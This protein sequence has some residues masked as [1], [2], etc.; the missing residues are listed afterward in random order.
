MLA[1]FHWF[2]WFETRL[3]PIKAL[4]LAKLLN[5]GFPSIKRGCSLALKELSD[6]HWFDWF[7]DLSTRF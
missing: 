7:I 2:Q 6:I 4:I 1:L 5:S 3:K